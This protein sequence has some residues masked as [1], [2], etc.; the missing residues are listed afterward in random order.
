M[1]TELYGQFKTINEA[2]EY[3]KDIGG[4]VVFVTQEIKWINPPPTQ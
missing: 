4:K 2:K 1:D 3:Q